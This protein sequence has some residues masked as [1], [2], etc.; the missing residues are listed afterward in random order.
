MTDGVLRRA[1]GSMSANLLAEWP[2]RDFSAVFVVAASKSRKKGWFLRVCQVCRVCQVDL[3]ADMGEV[4]FYD[5]AVGG[6]EGCELCCCGP[7][8]AKLVFGDT[9]PKLCVTSDLQ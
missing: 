2:T 1:L 5:T 6:E 3:L 9:N 8:V 4:D 7:W